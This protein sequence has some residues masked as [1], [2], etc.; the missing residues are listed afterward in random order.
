MLDGQQSDE[1]YMKE[2]YERFRKGVLANDASEFYDE[3][4]LLDIYDYA[5]DEGD[6]MTQLYVLLTG[7]RLYPGS[8]FLDE[9]KAFFLSAV[10]ED[11]ARQMFLRKGRRDSALWQVLGLSLDSY[12]DGNPEEGLSRILSTDFTLPCEGVIRIVDMLRDLDRLDLLAQNLNI[13]AEK[14]ED[15]NALFYEAAEAFYSD[16][17]FHSLARDIT[18][19]LTTREPFMADNW[20]LLS[21]SEMAL[22]HR[23]EALAAV[24]YALALDPLSERARLMKAICLIP[25]PDSREERVDIKAIDSAIAILRDVLTDNPVNSIAVKGLADAYARK[26]NNAAALEVLE[27][28]MKADKANAYT[29]LDVMRLHPAD[30]DRFFLLFDQAN[31]ASERPWIDMAGQI[32]SD[33]YHLGASQLLGWYNARHGLREGMEFYLLTLYRSRQFER[34]IDVFTDCCTPGKLAPGESFDLSTMAY[35]LLAASYLMTR[36]YDSA[37]RI[38]SLLLAQP[39]TPESIDDHI[40][41]KGIQVTLSFIRKLASEKSPVIGQPD[42]DPVCFQIGVS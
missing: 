12:P 19:D 38:C 27:A 35:L 29:L 36:E 15:P 10:N 22:G 33:G 7:A 20:V 14:A 1:Q 21:K 9:R 3:D 30:P 42:F 24:D 39:P 34:Y 4:E 41:W 26:G 28:F 2:L 40:R 37:E 17:R 16:E 18:E 25:A 6:E 23:D 31:G 11:A 32:D 13:I 8:D 5:Q